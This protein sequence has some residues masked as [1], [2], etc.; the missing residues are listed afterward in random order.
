MSFSI[1]PGVSEHNYVMIVGNF[2][3]ILTQVVL[4]KN[5]VNI[6]LKFSIKE[7][8]ESYFCSVLNFDAC[9]RIES[10]LVTVSVVHRELGN[11]GTIY[12]SSQ[13]DRGRSFRV[14]SLNIILRL[15]L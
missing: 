15:S 11:I 2:I 6:C 13:T 14:F 12:V 8:V 3:L 9:V 5:I 4:D 10:V 1:P 7:K